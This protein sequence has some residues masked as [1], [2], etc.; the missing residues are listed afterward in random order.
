MRARNVCC[1]AG[2]GLGLLLAL[3]AT[4]GLSAA[5]TPPLTPAQKERLKE[6]DRHK[7]DLKKAEA[8]GNLVEAI[9]A[10]ERMLAV[11]RQVF[12][13]VH[14]EAAGSLEWL[15]QLRAEHG[16]FAAARRDARDALALRTRLHGDR[17]WRT[18]DARLR[19]EDVALL[20]RLTVA[21]RDRVRE[22][23]ALMR[24]VVHLN[25]NARK[26][27]DA[28]PLAR[29]AVA[30]RR[31]LLG[32]NHALTASSLDWLG[33]LLTTQKDF[34][35][36]RKTYKQALAIRQ[37]VLGDDHP[38][39]AQSLDSLARV[40]FTQRD[41]ARA[42]SYH[43]QALA[44]RKRV[45]GVE[46]ADTA[47]SLAGLGSTLSRL[48][49]L[50]AAQT[51]HEQ[52]LAIRKKVYGESHSLTA[53]AAENV[54]LVAQRQGNHAV[55]R[56]HL[57]R[58]LAIRKKIL[59]E[60]AEA[61][62][63]TLDDLA[64]SLKAL[65]DTAGARRCY[66]EV[67]AL[68]R[69]TRG[70]GHPDTAAA[71]NRLAVQLTAV[72][73]W[74][75]ARPF[76]EQALS[77]YRKTRGENHPD[78]G[79]VLR[80]LGLTLTELGE[81][82]AAAPLLERAL[83]L[84]RKTPGK[85]A[86]DLAATLKLLGSARQAQKDH[87]A[88][89]RCYEEAL[90]LR[91]KALGETHSDVEE[92]LFRLGKVLRSRR[93]YPAARSYLERA[94]ALDRKAG[95][96]RRPRLIGCLTELGSLALEQ[97]DYATA[98]KACDEAL[99]LTRRARD[100]S[101]PLAPVSLAFLLSELG[102]YR[103]AQPILEQALAWSLKARGPEH[104]DT[105]S[106]HVNL[107]M[108][109]CDRR[110]FKEGRRHLERAL[111]LRRKLLG[112]EHFATHKARG[113]LAKLLIGQG[114]PAAIP[115]LEQTLA[116]ARKAYGEGHWFTIAC[117]EHLSVAQA[118]QGN[119]RKAQECC[120]QVL[121][122]RRKT[123]G[124][125]HPDTIKAR[126]R[127]ASLL[128]NKGDHAAAQVCYE[129]ALDLERKARGNRHPQV[130]ELHSRLANLLLE[131]GNPTA[132]RPHA[133]KALAIYKDSRGEE[134]SAVASSLRLLG[135]VLAA[136]GDYPM[137]RRCL[138]R[139]LA[140]CR[141]LHEPDG[142]QS[143][144]VLSKLGDLLGKQGGNAEALRA[145]EELLVLLR[146]APGTLQRA[147]SDREVAVLLTRLGDTRLKRGDRNGAR[148]HYRE[149]V[150]RMR[151]AYGPAHPET[152]FVLLK[153][154]EA[155][156]P[157]AVVRC[158]QQALAIYEKAYGEFHP[159]VALTLGFLARASQDGGDYET[160]RRFL[161]RSVRIYRKVHGNH[162]ERT[163]TYLWGLGRA[164]LGQGRLAEARAHLEEAFRIKL[165]WNRKLLGA[166]SEAEALN[167]VRT[168][169][170]GLGTLL[171]VLR[172]LPGTKPEEAYALVWQNRAQ[173]TR[174][175]AGRRS[176]VVA[177]PRMRD[178]RERLGRKRAE[179]AQLNRAAVPDGAEVAHL[180]R[181]AR[182]TREKEDLEREL[183][184]R[185]SPATSAEIGFDAL[186]RRL[187]PRTAVVDLVQYVFHEPPPGGRGPFRP[188]LQ[189]AAFVLRRTEGT[190]GYRVSWV[191]LGPLGPIWQA[192][193]D[194]REVLL[195]RRRSSGGEAPERILRRLI[196]DKIETHLAGCTAVLLI[197]DSVGGRVPWAALPGRRPGSYLLEDYL[198]ATA[199]YG[200]QLGELLA[201][202]P[203]AG[204][205][206][207]VVGG[208]DYDAAAPPRPFGPA[209]P[210]R[211]PAWDVSRRPSWGF[212]KGA[213]K[214]AQDITGLWPRPANLL[215]L[216]GEAANRA[217]VL[218]E[219]P[220]ARYV[221]L[222]T[223]GFFAD[224][225][226][227]SALAFSPADEKAGPAPGLWTPTSRADVAFRNPLVLSGIVLAGA[228]APR[229]AAADID[230]TADDG[231][232]TAE[233]VAELDLRDTELVVL[234]ACET[235][236]GGAAGGE[237]VLGLQRAFGMA[238]ARTTVASLWKVDDDATQRLMT[239]F[240]QNLW[241]KK[242][243]KAEALRQAQLALLRDPHGASGDGR[244]FEEVEGPARGSG[245]TDPRLWAAWTL[246]GDPGDLSA[247]HAVQREQGEETVGQRQPEAGRRLPPWLLA[248]AGLLIGAAVVLVLRGR[249]R[250]TILS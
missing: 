180:K 107:G 206:V 93:E 35:A 34:S 128:H 168:E 23:A 172:L 74:A 193:T 12:G 223:H 146:A 37:K 45:L 20:E 170:Y 7:D 156:V 81:P 69:K 184:E 244:G 55:A 131:R 207:L 136:E 225:K 196:W 247:L 163:G 150:K 137:A 88:A 62:V 91:I 210:R 242:L 9:A 84:H 186:A 159:D 57:E 115:L 29:Q 39:T 78:V 53:A 199:P 102:D 183:A 241:Q 16:D 228:N 25:N 113:H 214:E 216:R 77:I 11:E 116:A 141:K 80:N 237:G 8:A 114:D 13:N 151:R 201:A 235:G 169:Y 133:E 76:F 64:V 96:D 246:S 165:A 73:D 188:T 27:A 50:P 60:G 248:P 181:I 118:N 142:F 125:D 66:E 36:A 71:L 148:T 97:G 54:G 75:A 153:L 127:K 111:A 33:F 70:Q 30:L 40:F 160:A 51:C 185:L 236:L 110:A 1:W 162:H 173:A 32:D 94:C 215:F 182:I 175:L 48:G 72:E 44:L 192:M 28:L 135:E 166:M 105:A 147:L 219:L 47:R 167:L 83:A 130:A 174:V 171:S 21:E 89:Q 68:R 144:V 226:F 161:E 218:R 126:A 149:A 189:Y 202:R 4:V 191:H 233:E 176:R 109:L 95:A 211:G 140:L 249:G 234:S 15:A 85:D 143:L 222:A 100:G 92:L 177:D 22:A 5:D 157:A 17:H 238:G 106:A 41:Y 179:L 198:L 120:E 52:V 119:F 220:R 227:R 90:A 195:H 56:S 194:W 190:P 243:G 112:E 240:Y 63:G 79:L 221:H 152:A 154:A 19:L 104:L 138:E 250:R 164:E 203:A 178:M 49:N 101:G 132:A 204:D 59:P 145:S 31:R 245:R 197:P 99:E 26:P 121:T 65:G 209:R 239:L 139:S 122:V 98:R 229:R 108:L 213:L 24:R 10:A 212:L 18:T 38:S 87:A 205:R 200:Q 124:E 3:R 6:R 224:E 230:R 208:V 158:A 134:H 155:E 217:A 61:T 14:D 129:Q 232:V 43:E 123:L 58:C 187:A 117:L 82:N 231:I 46:H 67:L 42:K 86:R 103:A 2:W